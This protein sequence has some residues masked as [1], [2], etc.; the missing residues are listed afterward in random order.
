MPA[1]AAA[2]AD[3]AA[4]PRSCLH[5]PCA[6]GC[7]CR[8]SIGRKWRRLRRGRFRRRTPLLGG[9]RSVCLSCRREIVEF[10]FLDDPRLELAVLESPKPARRPFHDE[11]QHRLLDCLLDG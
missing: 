6:G 7:I 1:S 8:L 4:G 9:R 11:L 2:Q 3:L 5:L 10:V